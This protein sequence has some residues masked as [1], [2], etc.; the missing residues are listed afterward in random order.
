MAEN[1]FAAGLRGGSRIGVFEVETGDQGWEYTFEGR[2]TSSQANCLQMSQKLKMLAG[3]HEDHFLR[4]YD[5]NSS[6][7]RLI[8]TN[9]SN[10]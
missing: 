9:A 7:Y 5:P 6:K 2:G 10:R 3:G 8:Q 1:R 4:F